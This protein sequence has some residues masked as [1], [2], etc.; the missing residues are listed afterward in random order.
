M[1]DS[2]TTPLPRWDLSGIY[3]GLDSPQFEAGLA[4]LT[5]EIDG[6]D[7]FMATEGIH[8]GSSPAGD[9][10]MAAKVEGY[11][12]RMNQILRVY[13]TAEAFIYGHVSTDSFDP[14]AKRRLSELEILGVRLETQEMRFKGWL[15]QAIG[16]EK[17]LEAVL[18]QS[19]VGQE[20]AFYLRETLQQ[21]R[22]LMSEPE[23][24]LAA[25]LVLSGGAAFGKLQG[26]ITSQVAVPFQEDGETK[27][28][29]VSALQNIVRYHPDEAVR[30]RAFE[31]EILAWESVREPLAASL[32]GVKGH[33]NTLDRRRG[34]DDSLHAALEQA[35][36]DRQTLETMLGAMR[37]SFP[38]FRKYFRAK[39]RRL[40]KEKLAWWDLF[41]PVSAG[42][43]KFT[44]AEAHDF[45]LAQFGRFSDR[46]ASL[47][48]RAFDSRW[49]D[50]EPRMGK[51][52]GAFCMEVP[53]LEESRIL[54]NFDGSL[55]QLFT[56]AH[57]LG[58]AFHNECQVGLSI[59]NRRT[60]MTL[61][62]TASIFNESLI[63]EA[64]LEGASGPEEELSI[65]ENFLLGSAQIVV[66]IYSR[67]LFEKE[68][69]ERRQKAE[70]SADDLC[71]IMT[72][73]QRETYGDGLDENHLHPYM[74]AW[75]PHYYTPGLSY[76]NFPYAFG[77]LFGLGLYAEYKRRGAP[78]IADYESLLRST[79]IGTAAELAG[80]FG[81][82]LR[83]PAFWR[84]SM[85]IIEARLVRYLEL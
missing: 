57:E 78:F 16:D 40:G 48:G 84:G 30:R 80:R 68:V 41:A 24:A 59:L 62:E 39:A 75:K 15:G 18:K 43:R 64:A 83:Q 33:V 11:L 56:L 66:D 2:S 7:S 22:Y 23:E 27:E 34:R 60:P 31:A 77:L 25:E 63:T 45:L 36:M 46:V 71:E 13:K 12:T 51:R 20:H 5:A 72:R 38:M 37:E 50:A 35:R 74:W 10:M 76:Y 58:H 32:N 14:L 6:L 81:I 55:D 44:Y 67:F 54:A 17:R 28:L 42:E 1:T 4:S 79:G 65:L 29:P 26:T 73:C 47:A 61:A 9:G 8:R 82:D 69:F 19:P 3:P 53:G 70:L 85:K 21:S 52:G 49:I